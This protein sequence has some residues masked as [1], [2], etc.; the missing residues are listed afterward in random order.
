MFRFPRGFPGG[1]EGTRIQ[2]P[3]GGGGISLT[4]LVII[5][6]IMLFLGINPLDLLSEGQYPQVPQMPQQ[7]DVP[8]SPGRQAQRGPDIPGLPGGTAVRTEDDMKRF[9]SQ[10]LADTED[11][12]TRVFGGFGKRYTEPQIVLFDNADPHGLRHWAW[13]RWVRSTVR[14]IARSTSTCRSTT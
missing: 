4:T 8:K 1:G 12:W 6:V 9:V 10:V 14:S 7:T 11:V 5:G 3:V 2:I 13:R